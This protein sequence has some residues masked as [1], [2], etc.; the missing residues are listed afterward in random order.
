[1]KAVL[2]RHPGLRRLKDIIIFSTRGKIPLADM[3]SG[4]DYD[5]D[6]PWICWDRSIVDN[7]KN[8]RSFQA[9]QA[10][11]AEKYIEPADPEKRY[12]RDLHH[13]FRSPQFYKQFFRRGFASAIQ[14][15]LLG[16]CTN[17]LSRYTYFEGSK[18]IDRQQI[19]LARLCGILVDLPKQG[20]RPTR[21]AADMIYSLMNKYPGKPGYKDLANADGN[22]PTGDPESWYIL[23]RLILDVGKRKVAEKKQEFMN[24]LEV[25]ARWTD[26]HLTEL[27]RGINGECTSAKNKP[28][29][30]LLQRLDSDLQDVH[31]AWESAMRGTGRAGN[32]KAAVEPVLALFRSIRPAEEEAEQL[33]ADSRIREWYDNADQLFSEWSLL[34]ASKLFARCSITKLAWWM[35]MPEL[36]YMKAMH[37]ASERGPLPPRIVCNDMYILLKAV[38]PAPRDDDD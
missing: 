2:A 22:H 9:F 15:E 31:N 12:L 14:E 10:V 18:V 27:W 33:R 11:N 35:A 24:H 23:D 13:D 36:C 25:K 34:K 8:N 21:E 7:F 5:G 3:L 28:L 30:R 1:V 19:L 6:K 37:T 29:Q 17:A 32:F 20:N 26:P 38:A 4:G 16:L